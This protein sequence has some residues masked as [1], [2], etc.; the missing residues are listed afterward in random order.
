M[1]TASCDLQQGT[2][3]ST[4][5]SQPMGHQ[6]T[7]VYQST[8]LD[9]DLL[10]TES[11][12]T[13]INRRHSPR[14]RVPERGTRCRNA[15]CKRAPPSSWPAVIAADNCPGSR[16][17]FPRARIPRHPLREL[18]VDLANCIAMPRA[19]SGFVVGDPSLQPCAFWLSASQDRQRWTTS[20]C[21]P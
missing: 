15:C 12:G 3:Q 5:L 1:Q 7:I 13:C 4:P 17:A 19:L 21:A 6:S 9:K 10:P 20:A 11:I 8:E 2:V 14:N 16:K 18:V